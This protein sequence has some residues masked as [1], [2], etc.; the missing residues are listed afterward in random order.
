M[1]FGAEISG[2]LPAIKTVIRALD[3]EG[4]QGTKEPT[5]SVGTRHRSAYRLCGALPEVVATV[6]SQD[7]GVRFVMRKDDSVVYWDQ[8]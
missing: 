6:I 5:D 1:G 4:E 8:A 2:G 7:G 3:L